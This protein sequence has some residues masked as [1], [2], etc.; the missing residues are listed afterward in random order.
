[1]IHTLLLTLFLAMIAFFASSEIAFLSSNPVRL[2]RWAKT[3]HPA[4]G[5]AFRLLRHPDRFL[6]V[7]L[8]GTNLGIV[9]F[10]VLTTRALAQRWG[11][12]AEAAAPFLGT[13]I[14]LIFGEILPKSVARRDPNRTAVFSVRPLMVAH[15]IL[16]PL[17]IA[18]RATTS[19]VLKLLRI[20]SS[21]RRELFSR[22]DFQHAIR[23]GEEQGG[24]HPM[25][26]RAIAAAFS[27]SRM[28]VRDLMIPRW[29]IVAAPWDVTR[30]GLVEVIV[31]SGHSRLPIYRGR[32]DRI[33]GIV[34]AIDL[35]HADGGEWQLNAYLRQPRYVSPDERLVSLLRILKQEQTHMA[36]VQDRRRRVVGL[37]TL[38]DV[39]EELVGEI[40]DEHD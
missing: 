13:A 3:G 34:Q 32:M 40:S 8:V 15:V 22:E 18:V 10:S 36:L 33:E 24:V 39:V 21:R 28:R 37:V 31:K 25:E 14:I 38:E 17:T 26:R 35:T 9:A 19:V 7:I 2:R 16:L 29:E 6:S 30:E 4:A 12:P 23:T 5:M 20:R 27:L 1:M 11:Q